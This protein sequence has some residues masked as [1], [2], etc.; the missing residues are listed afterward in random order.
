MHPH[1]LPRAHKRARPLCGRDIGLEASA[2][3]SSEK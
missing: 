3:F 2:I 1:R